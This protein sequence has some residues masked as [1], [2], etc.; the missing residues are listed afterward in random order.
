VFERGA[1]NRAEEGEVCDLLVL[2]ALLW[3]AGVEQAP[4][5]DAHLQS[6]QLSEAGTL[7]P[8]PASAGLDETPLPLALDE[9]GRHI[10]LARISPQ[11][12]ILFPGSF[13]PFHYGHDLI[14]QAVQ[15]MTRKRVVFEIAAANADKPGIARDTLAARALQFRGRWPVLLT[16]NLPLF[17]DKA[18]ALGP[19]SFVLGLDTAVRLFDPRYFGGEGARDAVVDEFRRLGVSFYVCNRGDD[20]EQ[21]DALVRAPA[22][23]GLFV[24]LPLLIP[25]S[26]T[27]LRAGAGAP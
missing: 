14:A 15:A 26:S 5:P 4:L 25:V 16:E 20:P 2:D 24:P 9:E 23:A 7:A 11:T 18:R 19:F 3:A 17:I 10:D 1:L 6:K 27:D 12:H 21:F 13:N 22:Y 8:A